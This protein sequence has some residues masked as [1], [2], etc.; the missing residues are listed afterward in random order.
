MKIV[1]SKISAI[2]FVLDKPKEVELISLNSKGGCN[3]VAL[4]D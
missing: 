4:L 1:T 3:S 2:I